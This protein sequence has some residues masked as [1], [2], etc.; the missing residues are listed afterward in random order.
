[1]EPT[2]KITVS[3]SKPFYTAIGQEFH[4]AISRNASE[5][6]ELFTLVSR[7]GVKAVSGSAFSKHWRRTLI[8]NTP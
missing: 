3:L 4:D 2:V 8:T 6:S 1:L 5:T 7:V